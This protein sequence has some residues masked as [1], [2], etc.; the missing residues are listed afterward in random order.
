MRFGDL[1]TISKV[2]LGLV[3]LS[4]VVSFTTLS[5]TTINGVR[6]C[7][8]ADYGAIAFG[9]AALAVGVLGMLAARGLEGSARQLNLMVC[10]A[11]T[12]LGAVRL[13]YG[14]GLIGGAC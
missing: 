12:G 6:D 3:L 7:S 2:G 5:S 13:L 10:G 11:A 14:L 1:T 8:F 4:F 9:G